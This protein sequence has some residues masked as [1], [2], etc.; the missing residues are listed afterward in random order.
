MYAH[1]C[2]YVVAHARGKETER[3][4]SSHTDTTITGTASRELLLLLHHQRLQSRNVGPQRLLRLRSRVQ[5]PL[6]VRRVRARRLNV[7]VEGVDG[8]LLLLLLGGE[9]PLQRLHLLLGL[10]QLLP[11]PRELVFERL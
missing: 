8:H 7:G 9:G 3:E 4:R 10:G 11:E 1:A 6:Q 5:L 2:I